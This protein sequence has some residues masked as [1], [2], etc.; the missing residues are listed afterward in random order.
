MK[1]VKILLVAV[2]VIGLVVSIGC[3]KKAE[4]RTPA[5]V[6]KTEET[7][8]AGLDE[9]G[10]PFAVS[11]DSIVQ[12]SGADETLQQQQTV[13]FSKLL[14]LLP[15]APAGWKAEKPE[16]TMMEWGAFKFSSVERSY[17]KG[18]ADEP[19]SVRISIIDYAYHKE[20]YDIMTA[21]WK[22]SVESADGYSKTV[23]VEDCPG[24][25]EFT[26]ETKDG[27]LWLIVGKRFLLQIETSHQDPKALHE[28]AK[29]V[30]L[31]KLVELK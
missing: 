1:S 5:K 23:T 18:D 7:V 21:A 19:P 6:E 13:H 17:R 22:F 24:W 28:W 14:P 9:N 26:N 27:Y 3:K 2:L 4:E 10:K 20:Y 15:D 11:K 31:K 8:S 12:W 29:R 25:E 30:N 16:G